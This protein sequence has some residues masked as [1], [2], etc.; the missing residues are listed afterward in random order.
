MISTSGFMKGAKLDRKGDF[1][2]KKPITLID[3][4]GVCLVTFVMAR[5][6]DNNIDG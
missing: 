6:L 3:Q 2:T 4:L 1:S 5:K